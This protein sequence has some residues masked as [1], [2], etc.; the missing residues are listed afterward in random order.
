[1]RLAIAA[2]RVEEVQ[3]RQRA[4]REAQE[5]ARLEGALL[6]A[7]TAAHEL[8][9]ALSLPVGYAELLTLHP[10][11]AA[12]PELLSKVRQILEQAEHAAHVVAQLQRVV[13]L[14]RVPAPG[15]VGIDVIDLERSAAHPAASPAVNPPAN[16]SAG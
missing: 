9:N 11:V 5:K 14:E 15:N 6:A 7:R 8:N 2:R 10:T 12:N 3:A 13:R 16:P 1:V 4:E